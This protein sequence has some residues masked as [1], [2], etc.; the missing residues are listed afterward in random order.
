MH[1]DLAD[2][3]LLVHIA[4]A[5][6]LTGGAERAHLSLPAASMR[7]LMRF[8]TRPMIATRVVSVVVMVVS[9]DEEAASWQHAGCDH[10]GCPD[11]GRSYCSR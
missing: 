11:A 8:T 1:F 3:R 6:S 5:N 10:D 4:E 9:F 7:M 2:F